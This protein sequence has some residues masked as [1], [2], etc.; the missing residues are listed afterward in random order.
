MTESNDI[1]YRTR[2]F[3]NKYY[4]EASLVLEAID[5]TVDQDILIELTNPGYYKSY[6][7]KA[8]KYIETVSN[9]VVLCITVLGKGNQGSPPIAVCKTNLNIYL[10]LIDP[11]LLS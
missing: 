6:R 3:I 1:A 10:T 2:K 11:I 4:N 8:I 9:R 5:E 7:V